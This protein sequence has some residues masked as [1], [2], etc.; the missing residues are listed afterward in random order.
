VVEILGLRPELDRPLSFSEQL[1]DEPKSLP[2]RS[3]RVSFHLAQQR[4]TLL[5]FDQIGVKE[6]VDDAR[7]PSLGHWIRVLEVLGH[8]R[9]CPTIG[10]DAK[11]LNGPLA[12]VEFAAIRVEFVAALHRAPR[13][14]VPKHRARELSAQISA[15]V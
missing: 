5:W 2:Y 7:T 6:L 4:V 13:M 9:Q 8:P 1:L 12:R 11:Q 14:A 3:A 15:H 10:N